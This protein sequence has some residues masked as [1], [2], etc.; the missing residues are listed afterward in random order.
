MK[1][2]AIVVVDLQNDYWP[3]GKWPL[4]GIE[5]AAANAAK[6]IGKARDEGDILIHVRHEFTTPDAP[7]FVPGTEGA[8]INPLVQPAG[9]ETVILKNHPN[10]FRETGL[11]QMLDEQAVEEVV[12]VGAMSH[13]C[14]AATAR[15]AA[16]FGYDTVVVHDA[17]A[18]RDVEFDGTTVPASQVHSANMAAL[19]FAYG[20][21]IG[22]NEFLS[23]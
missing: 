9:T 23:R 16:D 6:V 7:F 18:T 8:R 20:K 19:A 21:V 11:K 14:I 5:E 17:C 1:K 22:T 15:A 4:K 2:R 13:M 12:V 3:S 10:S